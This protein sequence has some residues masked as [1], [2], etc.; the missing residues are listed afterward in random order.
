[1]DKIYMLFDN[2]KFKLV[3]LNILSKLIS[4]DEKVMHITEDD[5]NNLLYILS[6]LPEKKEKAILDP[7][8]FNIDFGNDSYS[9]NSGTCKNFDLLND[10][11]GDINDRWRN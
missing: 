2:Y 3:T 6:I 5:I 11:I 4:I 7:V 10:W 9:G 8:R 1:M